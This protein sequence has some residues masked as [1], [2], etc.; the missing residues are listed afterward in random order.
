MLHFAPDVRNLKEIMNIQK[1]RFKLRIYEAQQKLDPCAE[2][3]H[4]DAECWGDGPG[5]RRAQADN[6]QGDTGYRIQQYLWYIMI[7]HTTATVYSM[8]HHDTTHQ[9]NSLLYGAS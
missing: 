9:Y 1:N 3:E 8:V 2:P 5:R 4:Q 7:Q 6:L